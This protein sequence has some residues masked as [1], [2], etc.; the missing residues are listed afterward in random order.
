[1]I[2]PG[3]RR[4]N[5]L[6]STLGN[7]FVPGDWH[8][9]MAAKNIRGQQLAGHV[10]LTG[11][12]DFNWRAPAAANGS[13]ASSAYAR[14]VYQNGPNAI[15]PD[16]TLT[17]VFPGGFTPLFGTVFTPSLVVKKSAVQPAGAQPAE[18]SAYNFLS[19]AT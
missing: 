4:L 11:V 6:Q 3:R 2:Q 5:P 7:D 13:P 9:G 19:F 14:S 8:L 16:W 15:Y 17:S 10:L 18:L 1:M 12:N